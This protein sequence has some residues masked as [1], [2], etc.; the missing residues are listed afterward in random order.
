MN[1]TPNEAQERELKGLDH[2]INALKFR[3]ESA[4]KSRLI[5]IAL[6]DLEKLELIAV[7]A[8][9]EAYKDA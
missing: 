1:T 4:P 9:H 6:T 8:L 5:S 2:E 7:K 3:L